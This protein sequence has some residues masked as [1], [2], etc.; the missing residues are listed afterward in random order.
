[1]PEVEEV[2]PVVRRVAAE[3]F[4]PADIA[5]LGGLDGGVSLRTFDGGKVGQLLEVQL[6]AIAAQ[7]QARS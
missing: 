2:E 6:V 1:M 4:E 5:G 3:V 7:V